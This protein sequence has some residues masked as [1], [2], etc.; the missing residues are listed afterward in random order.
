MG[1]YLQGTSDSFVERSLLNLIDRDRNQSIQVLKAVLQ[2]IMLVHLEAFSLDKSK[3]ILI[4]LNSD[5][6]KHDRV[7]MDR[8]HDDEVEVLGLQQL[9]EVIDIG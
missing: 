9:I 7:V 6:A 4:I 2:Y 1:L 3:C 8:L 5:L